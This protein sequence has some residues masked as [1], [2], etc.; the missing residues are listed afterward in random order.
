VEAIFQKGGEMIKRKTNPYSRREMERTKRHVLAAGRELLLAAQGALRFCKDYVEFSPPR[1]SRPHL[2]N[3]F[4]RG[5]SM[6]DELGRGLLEAAP[7]KRAA[8]G[9]AKPILNIMEWEM[10][11]EA[12]S[13]RRARPKTASRKKKRTTKRKT[14]KKRR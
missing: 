4:Q 9:L 14:S 1:A 10:R 5:I 8:E 2:V 13:R 12:K 11:S 6:A 3:F 7:V